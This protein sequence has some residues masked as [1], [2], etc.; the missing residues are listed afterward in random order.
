MILLLLAAIPLFDGVTTQGWREY[1]GQDF[2]R[3]H[4]ELRDGA[5]CAKPGPYL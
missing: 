5:L 4:W 2:P 3:Q 1:L